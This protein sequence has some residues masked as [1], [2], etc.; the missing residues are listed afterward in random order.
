MFIAGA[1]YRSGVNCSDCHYHGEEL[2]EHSPGIRRQAEIQ[3]RQSLVLGMFCACP[4]ML[5]FLPRD[6]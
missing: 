6:L 5:F 3:G 4:L 1:Q 2:E